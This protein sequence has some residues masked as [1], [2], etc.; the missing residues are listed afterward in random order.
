M[1]NA[2]CHW[3][4][5]NVSSGIGKERDRLAA[6]YR[7]TL[8]EAMH[9]KRAV[10]TFYDRVVALAAR[11]G[12]RAEAHAMAC[13]HLHGYITTV[14][15]AEGIAELVDEEPW[16]D[17][18]IARIHSYVRTLCAKHKEVEELSNTIEYLNDLLDAQQTEDVVMR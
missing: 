2:S 11:K 4:P 12:K 1:V 18:Q 5:P 7:K 17:E 6:L 13:D 9:L 3:T 10:K 14:A 15:F 8:S 16:N